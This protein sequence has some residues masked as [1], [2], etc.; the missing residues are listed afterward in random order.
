MVNG[1]NS[2]R[3]DRSHLRCNSGGQDA[4]T[5][6]LDDRRLPQVRANRGRKDMQ[7]NANTFALVRDVGSSN[8]FIVG[9]FGSR[10]GPRAR[11]F[12]PSCRDRPQL[13]LAVNLPLMGYVIRMFPE[14]VSPAYALVLPVNV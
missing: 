14:S 4:G 2:H 1:T 3:S 7:R 9:L 8:P 13:N 10:D 6:G 5:A 11:Q 12:S